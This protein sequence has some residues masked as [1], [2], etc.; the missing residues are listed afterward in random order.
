MLIAAKLTLII[1]RNE[2]IELHSLL[3]FLAITQYQLE[4]TKLGKRWNIVQP[5]SD[6][7][8]PL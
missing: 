3:R 1:H 5:G 2:E 8:Y 4:L 6:L 7:S